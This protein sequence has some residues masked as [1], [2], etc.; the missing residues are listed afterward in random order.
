MKKTMEANQRFLITLLGL[1]VLL[2]HNGLS[3]AMK[4]SF[5]K[6]VGKQQIE[7]SFNPEAWRENF[8]V[9]LVDELNSHLENIG[10][11]KSLSE[12]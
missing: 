7:P 5:V 2:G 12:N 11:I 1:V 4:R 8:A 3:N 6:P 10:S 9:G